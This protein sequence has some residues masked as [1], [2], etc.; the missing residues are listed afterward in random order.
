MPGDDLTSHPLMGGAPTWLPLAHA[1]ALADGAAHVWLADVERLRPMLDL[2]AGLLSDDERRRADAFARPDD[3]QRFT[4]THGLLRRLLGEYLEVSPAELRFRTEAHGKPWLAS[5]SSPM[6]FN[7]SHADACVLIAVA[8]GREVG[9]DIERVG[10]QSADHLSAADFFS[11][12]ERASLAALP[13]DERLEAFYRCWTRKEAYLK[14][15]GAG[16]T[17]PL[18]AFTVPLTPIPPS[19]RRLL[20]ESS[21]PGARRWRLQDLPPVEGYAASLVLSHTPQRATSLMWVRFEP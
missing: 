18:D 20:T 3:R 2:F 6:A 9:V 19:Q 13:A 7:V 21:A 15:T 1:P 4:L 16:L 17:T 10:G 5:P 11:T 8:R 14:A 12:E